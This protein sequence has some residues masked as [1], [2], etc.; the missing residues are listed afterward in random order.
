MKYGISIRT[1]TDDWEMINQKYDT[2]DEA[3]EQAKRF[4]EQRIDSCKV[5]TV[6]VQRSAN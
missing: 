2:F 5:L 1:N 3:W 6:V 4:A